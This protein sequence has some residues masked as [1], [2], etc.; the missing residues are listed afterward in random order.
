LRLRFYLQNIPYCQGI[1]RIRIGIPGNS[2][3]IRRGILG[4]SPEYFRNSYFCPLF[5]RAS[6]FLIKYLKAFNGNFNEI[7]NFSKILVNK[8]SEFP[9]ISIS[10][11]KWF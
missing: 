1:R 4:Y 7:I 3:N 8:A 2:T 9:I 10:S 5:T 6:M 11:R